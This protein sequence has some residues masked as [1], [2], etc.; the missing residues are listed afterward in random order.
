MGKFKILVQPFFLNK[1]SYSESFINQNLKNWFCSISNESATIILFEQE[2]ENSQMKLL[3][4]ENI[5][6]YRKQMLLTQEQLAEAMGVSV[7]TV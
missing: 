4:N 3:L 5:R 6:N 7:A 1:F 2:K